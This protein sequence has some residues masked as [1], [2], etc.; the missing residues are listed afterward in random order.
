MPCHET[1]SCPRCSAAFEC[2]VGNVTACQCDGITFNDAEK[3]YIA[4]NYA[5][6]LCRKCL[7]EIRHEIRLKSFNEKVNQILPPLKK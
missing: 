3:D 1:K 2:K 5:D 4:R 7:L 6:C